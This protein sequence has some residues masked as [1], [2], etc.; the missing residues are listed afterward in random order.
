MSNKWN[1]SC[2]DQGMNATNGV[3]LGLLLCGFVAQLVEHSNTH[4]GGFKPC[5]S[6]DCFRLLLVEFPYYTL[7]GNITG[8]LPVYNLCQ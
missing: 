7:S 3:I 1:K 2:F 6:L 4:G 5:Q 8:L